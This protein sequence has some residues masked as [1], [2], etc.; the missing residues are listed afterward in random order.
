MKLS[1]SRV[2]SVS[3]KPEPACLASEK[4]ARLSRKPLLTPGLSSHHHALP[5]NIPGT[6]IA[7]LP[8]YR[9]PILLPQPKAE[10]FYGHESTAHLCARFIT[11]LFACPA[12]ASTRS[13]LPFFV[14]YALH[15]TKLHHS[16]TFAAL[17]SFSVSSPVFQR[18]VLHPDIGCSSHPSRSPPKSSAM[19]QTATSPW[20]PSPR[21]CFPSARSTRWNE[22]CARTSSGSS[23]SIHQ[24]SPIS[25][26]RSSAISMFQRSWPV[27]AGTFAPDGLCRKLI[28]RRSSNQ[29][30]HTPRRVHASH[31]FPMSHLAHPSSS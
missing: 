27:S 21:A 20:P 4:R 14:A 25:K 3:P 19:T 30:R 23:R 31:S 22:K 11:N 1:S 28:S 6:S 13:K 18:P 17:A 29:R 9:Q 5:T 10:P 2:H 24:T 16:V 8:S 7:A 26:P 15:R 12:S